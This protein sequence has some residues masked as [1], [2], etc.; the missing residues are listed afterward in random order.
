M[1][2]LKNVGAGPVS[3]QKEV[4]DNCPDFLKRSKQK[5]IECSS[6]HSNFNG[7]TLIALIITVIVML[8]L[9]GVTIN[10]ALNGGLFESA[11]KAATET[12]KEAEKEQL[13]SAVVGAMGTDGKVD[14]TKI[15]LPDGFQKDDSKSTETKLVV[16]GKEG[17]YW[18]V[19]LNTAAIKEYSESSTGATTYTFTIG[20]LGDRG[21]LEQSFYNEDRDFIWTKEEFFPENISEELKNSTLKIN[22]DD[23]EILTYNVKSSYKNILTEGDGS[24]EPNSYYIVLNGDDVAFLAM[25]E[26]GELITKQNYEN[27]K[28]V[29]FTISMAE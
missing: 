13:L 18:E 8:I 27:Y 4:I 15:S 26:K 2:K 5:N 21:L 28:D 14:S 11:T 6:V 19:N 23:N 12:Q 1:K 22:L 16:K 29:S 7:I 10:V 3:A 25:N 20:E 24:G 9:V 17:I